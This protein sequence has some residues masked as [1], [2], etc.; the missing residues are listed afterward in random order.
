MGFKKGDILFFSTTEFV[1][2]YLV[3]LAVWRLGGAVRGTS[4]FET[5]GTQIIFHCSFLKKNQKVES[6]MHQMSQVDAK[7][8]CVDKETDANVRNAAHILGS[9]NFIFLSIG[10]SLVEGATHLSELVNDDGSG[11]FFN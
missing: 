9:Q 11:L 4:A 6:Y 1:D 3:Q 8:V 2:L 7:F 5:K 10:E